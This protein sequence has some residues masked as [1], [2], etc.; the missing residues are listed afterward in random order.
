MGEEGGR[1]GGAVHCIKWC[2]SGAW[3]NP[4]EYL[5]EDNIVSTDGG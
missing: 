3:E 5:N 1:K 2:P 4:V